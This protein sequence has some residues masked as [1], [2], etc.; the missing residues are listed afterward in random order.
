MRCTSNKGLSDKKN[1]ETQPPVSALVRGSRTY[2]LTTNRLTNQPAH[3]PTDSRTNRLTNQ[4][5]VINPNLH[6]N[7]EKYYSKNQT[8]LAL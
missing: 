1:G 4:Q 2:R 7:S 3:E 6:Q 8:D 5:A